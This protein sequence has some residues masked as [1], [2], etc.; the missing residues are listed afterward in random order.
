MRRLAFA[1][2]ALGLALGVAPTASAQATPAPERTHRGV[3]LGGG[4][5]GGLDDDGNGGGGGYFRIGGTPSQKL[6]LGGEAIGFGR[7][8]NDVT[9]S[10]GNA[11]FV[12]L[13]YPSERGFFLK[14]GVGFATVEAS[15]SEGD[16][17][18]SVTESGFGSTVGLGYDI[19]IGGNLYLTPNADMLIQV[20]DGDS[21]LLWLF[22]L[23]I[24]MH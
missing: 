4:L 5:G 24:G 22:T 3:W 23:G 18:V 10:Q 8:E 20:I 11:T 9:L 21:L 12:A 1:T 6:L 19:R 15:T 16:V 7:E 14:G 13:L 17:T 2:I